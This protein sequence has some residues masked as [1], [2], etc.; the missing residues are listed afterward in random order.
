[1][2]N[3]VLALL[4]LALGSAPA[5][6]QSERWA[7]KLFKGGTSHDFGNQPRGSLLHHRFTMYNIYAVPL[8]IMPIRTSCGCVTAT[9]SKETLQPREEAFLDVTMDTHKFAGAKTVSVFVTVG[10]QFQSTATLQV[11]ANSRT[12]VVFNPGEVNFGPVQRGQTPTREVD[13]EYAGQ[14]DWRIS[15]VVTNDAPVS[16]KVE[17]L[18]RRPGRVGYKLKVTLKPDTQ[19]GS[20]KY[21]LFL[22]TND[23]ASPMVT[24]LVEATV[25]A[26]LSVQPGLLSLGS[27]QAGTAVE[28]RV[29]V[30]GSKPF[31]ILAIEGL[32]EGLTAQAPPNAAQTHIITFKIQPGQAGELRRQIV[33]KTD[34]DKDTSARVVVEGQVVP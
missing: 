3:A 13:V 33:F 17:D 7:N 5:A 19:P 10:P 12:D 23:P 21:D 4:V 27:V 20:H 31:R 32:G 9:P 26:A 25:Q 22:K 1:M 8:T 11:L 28:R 34:L 15:E 18:Y 14:L 16:V 30:L 2:R 29:V 6:A 24:L